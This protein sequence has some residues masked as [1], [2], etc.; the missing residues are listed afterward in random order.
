[1][2]EQI[3]VKVI[4]PYDI[5]TEE[6]FQH[7]GHAQ[8][9]KLYELKPVDEGVEV[10]AQIFGFQG[11]AGHDALA[12]AVRDLGADILVCGGIGMGALQ[13]LSELGV[14]VCPGIEGS[15][16]KA[17]E[18]LVTGT[19]VQNF[20]PTCG[21]GCHDDAEGESCGC[22]CHDDGEGCGCGCDAEGEAESDCGC[23]CGC[24]TEQ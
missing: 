22:G 1:M 4:M 3:T 17:L 8:N 2:E 16:D 9:F 21:C 24:S 15:A 19:L 7:F 14:R 10:T 13:A 23:G 5:E 18:D 11:E 20:G 6:I 12:A